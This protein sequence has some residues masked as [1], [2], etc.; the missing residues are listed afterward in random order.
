MAG[1]VLPGAVA[2][3]LDD[4]PARDSPGG[5][6]RQQRRRKQASREPGPAA[7]P[8]PSRPRLRHV[9]R[10][11]TAVW[12]V[13]HQD[14]AADRDL[15]VPD[16]RAQRETIAA[17]PGA[18]ARDDDVTVFSHKLSVTALGMGHIIR[19]GLITSP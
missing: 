3:E 12:G 8:S 2:G 19:F 15:R 13:R 1:D 5:D 14:H 11:G 7:Y 16:E 9:C 18:P 10:T 6:R 17:P 4:D